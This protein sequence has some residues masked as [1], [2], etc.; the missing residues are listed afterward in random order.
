M[1]SIQYLKLPQSTQYYF[2][3]SKRKWKMNLVWIGS[4]LNLIKSKRFSWGLFL[5]EDYHLRFDE[6]ISFTEGI[7]STFD[8]FSSLK[9]ILSCL[10]WF[11]TKF[12]FSSVW[13]L[14]QLYRQKKIILDQN[15]FS[16]HIY[17]I[18]KWKTLYVFILKHNMLFMI[19]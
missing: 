3:N 14:K 15:M 9:L 8:V 12:W 7:L 6:K 5:I 17:I 4:I 1:D 16:L 2:K 18:K 19:K 13:I 11:L 10:N